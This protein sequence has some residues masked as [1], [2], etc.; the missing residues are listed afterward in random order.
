VILTVGEMLSAPTSQALV[1][2]FSPEDMRGRYMAIFGMSWALPSTV[3]PLVSGYIMDNYNPNWV[4]YLCGV[5]AILAVL[6][7]LLLESLTGERLKPAAKP[8]EVEAVG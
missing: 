5:L 3:V 7:L 2:Q 6:G 8:A 4:W 1:A